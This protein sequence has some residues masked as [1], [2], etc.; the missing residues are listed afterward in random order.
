MNACMAALRERQLE[1]DLKPDAGNDQARG[2]E[3]EQG[4]SERD[5]Q[6]APTAQTKTVRSAP[7]TS[8]TRTGSHARCASL[9]IRNIASTGAEAMAVKL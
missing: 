6:R 3:E 4:E 7:T 1:M 2:S 9:C 5:A 8:R